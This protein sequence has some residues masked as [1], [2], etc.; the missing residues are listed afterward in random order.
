MLINTV[1]QLLEVKNPEDLTVEEVLTESG[2]STGSL[3]HHFEDFADLVDHAVI[4][5]YAADIDANIEVLI[6]VI[7]GATDRRSLLKGLRGTTI[8][9]VST[10]R[11]AQRSVRAQVMARAVSSERFREA[12]V[13]HQQRL[14]EAVADLVRELQA[15]ALFDPGLDPVAASIF[16]QAYNMGFVVNDVSGHPADEGS[17]AALVMQVLERSFLAAET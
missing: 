14:T 5:R 17:L 9:T 6:G 2:I 12:L 4:A 16:I 1:V 15:K 8:A 11:V 13:P 3:Y 10:D 7:V